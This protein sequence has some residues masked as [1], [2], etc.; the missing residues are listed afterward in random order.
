MAAMHRS[1]YPWGGFRALLALACA[2]AQRGA[3]REAEATLAML[4]EPDRVFRDPGPVVRVFTGALQ[5]LVRAYAAGEKLTLTLQVTDVLRQVST[6]SYSLAPLCALVELADCTAAPPLAE[7]PYQALGMAAQRGVLFSSGWMFLI[8]RV[9]GVAATLFRQWDTAEAHLQAALDIAN[10]VGARPELGRTY[11][12]YAR[13]LT[14]RG[15]PGDSQRAIE[16]MTRAGSIFH[17]L[18]MTPFVQ[19][20]QQLREA[21]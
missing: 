15:M 12:D 4:L 8:P 6:D 7:Q 14:A 10:R 13:M 9:L 1:G 18:D 2:Q 17:A 5:E 19:R 20:V 21:L 3:W 11:L 16:Y